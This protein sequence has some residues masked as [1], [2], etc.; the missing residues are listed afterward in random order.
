M[1]LAA[2]LSCLALLAGL[3]TSAPGQ[4]RGNVEFLITKITKNL[5]TT[6]Q[7]TFTGAQQYQANQ[8]DRWLEVEVE[9]AT[10]PEFT[11]ELTLKYFILVNG[12][13]LTG[14][15]THTN[16]AAGRE[17]HSVMY[18]PPRTLARLMGNRTLA[19]NSVQNIAVQ[20]SQ[21]GA[22]KS[23]LSEA[24]AAPQWFAS[25]PNITGL[26]LN[27]NETP[28]APLYWDRYEQIKASV[29]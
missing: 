7:F 8:R 13:L 14:E 21:Q 16:V 3:P 15:V 22:V 27:K 29:R 19:P 24:R 4:A 18:V 10:A 23:E 9:F 20:L 1:K 25:L 2:I 28:F 12:K 11:D 6:P 17:H 5:I 26:V